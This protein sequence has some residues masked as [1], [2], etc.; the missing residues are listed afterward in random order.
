MA[1]GAQ[2]IQVRRRLLPG[3]ASPTRSRLATGESKSERPRDDIYPDYFDV[4]QYNERT[5]TEPQQILHEVLP[6]MEAAG[7]L[8]PFSDRFW[9]AIEEGFHKL[10][11]PNLKKRQEFIQERGIDKKMTGHHASGQLHTQVRKE[12][13]QHHTVLTPWVAGEKMPPLQSEFAVEPK[14]ELAPLSVH[15][16]VITSYGEKLF[17]PKGHEP[18]IVFNISSKDQAPIYRVAEV[19]E[20][21]KGSALI[22]WVDVQGGQIAMYAKGKYFFVDAAIEEPQRQGEMPVMRLKGSDVAKRECY[23]VQAHNIYSPQE[24]DEIRKGNH[25][26]HFSASAQL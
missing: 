13:L 7:E 2:D 24:V 4:P 19:M 8:G 6:F 9:L 26:I 16:S 18:I 25:P 23:I 12:W 14:T 10:H 21:Y 22:R 20:V 11:L 3:A 15:M 5:A 1:E 17:V